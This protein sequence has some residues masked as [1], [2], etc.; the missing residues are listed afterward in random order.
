[1]IAKEAGAEDESVSNEC[2]P[3][4]S[5]VSCWLTSDLEHLGDG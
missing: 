5:V 2:I 1:M 4:R 3:G